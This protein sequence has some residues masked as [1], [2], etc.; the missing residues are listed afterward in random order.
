MLHRLGV[1][2]KSSG[3]ASS[4]RELAHRSTTGQAYVQ[5]SRAA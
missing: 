4:L 2:E 1:G 3:A 5:I